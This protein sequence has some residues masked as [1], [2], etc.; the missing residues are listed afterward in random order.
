M[1]SIRK[2]VRL[3]ES[4][5]TNKNLELLK[6]FKTDDANLSEIW[7]LFV[8]WAVYDTDGEL[9]SIIE[10]I[11]GKSHSHEDFEDEY[12]DIIELSPEEILPKIDKTIIDKFKRDFD[13]HLSE[14]K[15]LSNTKLIFDLLSTSLLPDDSI[16]I[17]YTDDPEKIVEQ[18]FTRGIPYMSMLGETV[19]YNLS[20]TVGYNFAYLESDSEHNYQQGGFK[21]KGF[22]K[23][24][25]TG[26]YVHHR[27]DSDKQVIFWGGYIDKK[28]IIDYGYVD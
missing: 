19:R 26:V 17:H 25:S 14:L 12:D 27:G 13:G 18:G 21:K 15:E 6:Y 8:Q 11:T 2:Y 16:L 22:V 28:D 5:S 24:K 20:N 7:P 23:F 3:I 9:V 10:R 4:H 1:S